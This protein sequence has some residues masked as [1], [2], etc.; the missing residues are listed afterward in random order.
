MK[1]RILYLAITLA[2]F[3]L[4]SANARAA[5][6]NWTNA[7][8]GNWSTAANWSPN[9]VPGTIDIAIITNT[10]SYTVSLNTSATVAGFILGASSGVTTQAFSMNG[11]NLVLNGPGTVTA[12]GVL[13]G[14][15]S[16]YAPLTNSGIYIVNYH[17]QGQQYGGGGLVNQLGGLINWQGA[18]NISGEHSF[19]QSVPFDYF[20]NRGMITKTGGTNIIDCQVFDN[21]PG[22]ITNLAGTLALG[23]FQTN[24]AGTYYAAADATIQFNAVNDGTN[25]VS[26]GTPLMLGGNGQFQFLSG[27]LYYPSNS[28]PNLALLGT[29]LELGPAFEGGA[30]TNLAL[31]GI[32]LSNSLPVTGIFAATNS[33]VLGNFTVASGGVFT[34]SNAATFGSVTVAGGA[35]FIANGGS[36]NTLGFPSFG[37]SLTVAHGGVMTLAGNFGVKA[38]ITNA[39]TVTISNAVVNVFYDPSHNLFAGMVNQ[40]GGLMNLGNNVGI[41]NMTGN[42]NVGNSNSYFINQGM[43]VQLPGTGTTNIISCPASAQVGV[44]QISINLAFNFDNQQGTISNLSGALAL[45]GFRT[46]LAG[47]FYT[48]AGAT[49]Q[50]GGGT[51]ATPLV[52]GTPLVLG[53]SG[54]YQFFSGYLYLPANTIP[55]LS[56]QAGLLE[57]GPGFQGG[58]ITNLT[59]AG[60]ALTNQLT[61]TL[62]IKGSF[63][64]LNSGNSASL[65]FLRF[66]WDGFYGNGVYGNYGVAGGGV[67]TVSNATMNGAMA[68]ANAGELK[69]ERALMYGAVM[70]ANGGLITVTNGGGTIYPSSSLTVAAGGT[71]DITQ[72]SLTVEAPLTNAGTININSPIAAGFGAG[73]F[74]INDGVSYNGGIINQVSGLINLASD[75]TSLNT[76]GDFFGGHEYIVNQG[77]I[78]KSAGTNICV[79]LSPFLTNSGAITVQSGIISMRPL[80]M[81]AG[82]SL[83]VGLNSAANYGSFIVT[84]SSPDLT[85]TQPLAGAFN[86]TLNNGYVPVTGAAFNVLSYGAF[87]GNFASLG[88]PG[89]ISW[90]TSYGSTN[91]T[92]VAGGGKPRFGTLNLSGTNLIFNGLN[93]SPGSNCVILASTNLTLPLANWSALSTNTFDGSGQFHYTN[94]LNLASPRQFFIFKLP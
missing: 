12:H 15:L 72:A 57:L 46:N 19:F 6:I 91:F 10:G 39:G 7:V 3:A 62:P 4:A 30:I 36:A 17:A 33:P 84:A 94:H 13:N 45:S 83:N 65:N 24:F 69:M 48:A 44:Q 32:V 16:L 11:Q 1:P 14:G 78:I 87:T 52:P 53:G 88:L 75:R 58:A 40:S 81:Q 73:L 29:R 50:L 20:I 74:C 89:A 56:L 82:G 43:I 92:L 21:A 85:G 18:G 49:T 93:G 47:T 80:V 59:L 70:V 66:G 31:D 34:G 61:T 9:Q 25:I 8:S 41:Y 77:T 86:V 76:D 5:T 60:I 63:T 38:P 67:L 27:I 54:Q 22:T 71:V 2:G 68:V 37:G 55:N 79:V 42:G 64:V 35:Q 28:I 51:A 90:Q 26:A 23:T